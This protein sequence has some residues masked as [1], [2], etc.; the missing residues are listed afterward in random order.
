ML[1]YCSWYIEYIMSDPF[2]FILLAFLNVIAFVLPMCMELSLNSSEINKN[3]QQLHKEKL[4][5]KSK[6]EQYQN[7]IDEAINDIAK[8]TDVYNENIRKL[9]KEIIK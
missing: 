9:N 7:N 1:T 8:A 2:N 3:W 5:N 4:S 6:A